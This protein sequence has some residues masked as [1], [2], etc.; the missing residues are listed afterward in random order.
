MAA[1]AYAASNFDHSLFAQRVRERL[2]QRALRCV[3]FVPAS[4]LM[5]ISSSG[6][7]AAL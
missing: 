2:Q 3:A 4:V 1:R 5:M 6:A 7:V